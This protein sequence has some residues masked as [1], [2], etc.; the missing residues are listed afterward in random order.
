GLAGT[1][2]YKI[3][4]GTPFSSGAN[5]YATIQGAEVPVPV[6]ADPSTE[7][8]ALTKPSTSARFA[9]AWTTTTAQNSPLTIKLNFTGTRRVAVYCTDWLN[10]GTVLERI[11]V[12][13]SADTSFS[14]PL[15][16]RDFIVP[17]N[18]V[19]FVWKLTG[20]KTIRVLKPDGTAGNKAMVS[21]IFFD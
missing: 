18:G 7:T 9:A 16:T 2:G 14:S 11:Q 1:G 13:E 4:A 12:F 10:T 20:P 21:A 19:Y 15:D 6:F 3:A 5:D 17:P 8:R